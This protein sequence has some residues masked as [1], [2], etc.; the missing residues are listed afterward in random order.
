[1]GRDCNLVRDISRLLGVT[2]AGVLSWD[3]NRYWETR[4]I[5]AWGVQSPMRP[6]EEPGFGVQVA[7]WRD[8]AYLSSG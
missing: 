8:V 2:W 5:A 3:V 7:W 1:M 6:L 4:F